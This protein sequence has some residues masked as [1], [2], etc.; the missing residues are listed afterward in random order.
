MSGTGECMMVK[1]RGFLFALLFPCIVFAG[2]DVPTIDDRKTTPP[3]VSGKVL[4]IIG[5]VLLVESRGKE[6]SVLTDSSTHIFTVYGG[7]VLLHEICARSNIAIWYQS[8]EANIR[9]ASAVSIRV[10]NTC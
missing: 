3:M 1:I 6:I 2:Y 9:I 5:N 4:E 10:P 8:P 7:L